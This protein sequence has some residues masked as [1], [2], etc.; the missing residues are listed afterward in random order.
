MLK[1]VGAVIVTAFSLFSA[2]GGAAQKVDINQ[3]KGLDV[4]EGLKE[5]IG[6]MMVEMRG[7]KNEN[8]ALQNRTQIVEAGLRNKTLV[9]EELRGEISWL[10]SDRDAFQNKTRVVEAQLRGEISWLKKDIDA[11][12]N[13]T[14]RRRGEEQTPVCGREA[15]DNMLAVCCASGAPAGN[16]HR[17]Q[18]FVGCD[19]LPPTCSLD[20]SFRFIS[21]FDNCHDQALMQG[22][23]AEELTDWTSFY[24]VCS[25]VEQSAAEMGALQPVNVKMFRIIID[26]EA[27]QQAAMANDGSGAPSPPFGPVVLPPSG[28]PVEPAPGG[29]EVTDVE[30]YHAQCTTA[31][32]LTCV[33][34]CNATHHGFELL[35]T[36]DGTDTK[37]SC[38]LAHGLY[39]WTGQA[40]LGGYIGSDFESFFSAVNS[41]AAGTYA[42]TLREDAHIITDMTIRP[43]Q[44]VK[45]S[46]DGMLAQAPHMG[47]GDVVVQERASF[48]LVFVT[49]S[50]AISVVA[51]GSVNLVE[52]VLE[53]HASLSVGSG[54]SL[55]VRSMELR[56]D[57]L[58]GLE[59]QVNGVGTALRLVDVS[60]PE[61]LDAGTLSGTATTSADGIKTIVP[62][63]FGRRTPGTF[64]V[65][66]GPC[67]ISEGGRCVGRFGG[68]LPNEDCEI[69][70]RGDGGVLGEC[71]RFDTGGP[72]HGRPG[73]HCCDFVTLGETQYSG[74][75]CPQ[76]SPLRRGDAVSWHSDSTHQ[77]EDQLESSNDWNGCRAKNLCGLPET[78][79]GLGGGWQICFDRMAAPIEP[80]GPIASTDRKGAT[81]VVTAGECTTFNGGR[82]VGRP[83]GYWPNERCTI[84]VGGE[85]GVLGP[86]GVFDMEDVCYDYLTLPGPARPGAP[87][88]DH[89]D[90]QPGNNWAE[91]DCPE[92]VELAPGALLQWIASSSGQGSVGWNDR[93]CTAKGICGADFSMDGFGGGWQICF[94]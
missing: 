21:I 51:G 93:G 39:S 77:G 61:N 40:S 71:G 44:I 92:G 49:V 42:A 9:E 81:F 15:V 46:G 43:G 37:F 76:G 56:S 89:G 63:H 23:S 60:D 72:A 54:G 53:G 50:G 58:R 78:T 16:G 75:D 25:E 85:G 12:Q 88:C 84:M 1:S 62:P 41:A 6:S 79:H 74:S 35:A 22:L 69:T 90:T 14:Q 82:C 65:N 45:L 47:R 30:Q 2:G 94:A 26:Q 10:K 19:S 86:C 48:S 67:I 59:D 34:A 68:Y 66:S 20:C 8:A 18:E 83:D 64:V 17:L 3:L 11:F 28:S 38:N 31:N 70:V 55:T 33:P 36:I 5:V 29:G 27:E 13:K 73:V 52:C 4:P 32:I 80:P 24:A 87:Q 91:S 7:L 57:V